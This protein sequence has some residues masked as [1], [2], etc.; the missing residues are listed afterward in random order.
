MQDCALICVEVDLGKGLPE[1]IKP[2]VDDWTNIQQLD[3]DQIP[4]KCKVCHEYGHF[5]N[6]CSKLAD[7]ENVSQDEQRETVKKKKTAPSPK[8]NP[9]AVPPK[10]KKTI[11]ST[12]SLLNSSTPS[13][14]HPLPP[15]ISSNPF[16][17]ISPWR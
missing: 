8:A 6:C 10:T 7:F 5:S 15:P 11:P 17:T 2:Q 4:F 1:A 13:L 16:S 14:T 3:Y 9:E 12:S